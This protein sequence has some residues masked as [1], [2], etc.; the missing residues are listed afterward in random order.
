MASKQ[1]AA[2]IPLCHPIPLEAV[3]LSSCW[4]PTNE[5]E[6]TA[7]VVANWKTGVEMEALVAVSVAALTVY[8]MCKAVDRSMEVFTWPFT[9]N[10]AERVDCF[11]ENRPERPL[12]MSTATGAQPSAASRRDPGLVPYLSR[13]I[14]IKFAFADREALGEVE[15]TLNETLSSPSPAFDEVLGYVSS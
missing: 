13:E 1:T 15:R 8:D 12:F 5:L 4:T 2:L 9:T 3:E 11:K 6:W 10:R 14:G 7:T